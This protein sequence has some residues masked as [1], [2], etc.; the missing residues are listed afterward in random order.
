MQAM[1][2]TQPGGPEVLRLCE[3]PTPEPVADQIR[4]RVCATALNRADLVQRMGRYTAPFGAP[5]DIPGLEFAGSVDA[6]G[7]LVE[8]LRP[9][10]RV[11]GIVGG[12]AYAEYLLTSERM[13]VPIP[14]NLDWEQAAAVPEVF[15]TAHDAL[16]TQARFT[17]G[18]R[19][20]VHAV[21]S[22]VGTAAIQLIRAT[23]GISFGTARSADKLQA[24][25]DLGLDVALPA[26]GW[27]AELER[28]T[29]QSGV[30]V[31]LDFVGSAYL[32]DNLNALATR[33][34]LV[35]IGLM[36]GAQAQID[37]GVIQRKRL[38]MIGTVLRAR[39]LEEKIA[40]TQAFERQ[41]VPLLERRSVRP[42]VDRVFELQDAAEAH[43]YME[44]NANFGKIV[45]RVA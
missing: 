17:S 24:A 33:G 15:M 20:L 35:L 11:F 30:H 26:E 18:E 37:L 41:V 36:S 8:R 45:L 5:Q 9:G 25:R 1:T 16:F 27:P 31:V 13:A 6:V 7:P 4:V 29:S 28:Q 34:R 3:M 23:G 32:A 39:P 19:V 14:A 43:R 21:G 42:V 10:D 12:G 38:Q 44:Q 40:V 22:G 2:I